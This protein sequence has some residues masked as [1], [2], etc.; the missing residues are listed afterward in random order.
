MVKSTTKPKTYHEL[1]VQAGF[2]DGIVAEKQ[3]T[4]KWKAYDSQHDKE[5]TAQATGHVDG[6][7][8]VLPGVIRL[9]VAGITHVHGLKLD[10]LY[11]DDVG[12]IAYLDMKSEASELPRQRPNESPMAYLNRMQQLDRADVD[13]VIGPVESEPSRSDSEDDNED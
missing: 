10:Q 9:T 2:T 5:F 12:W 4:V 1:L 8:Q 13:V 6:A 3:I 11:F 7:S